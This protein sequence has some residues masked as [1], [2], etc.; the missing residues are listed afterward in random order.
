ME[1]TIAIDNAT[2][3]TVNNGMPASAN[4]WQFYYTNG[5]SHWSVLYVGGGII[6]NILAYK[7][8]HIEIAFKKYLIKIDYYSY[9]YRDPKIVHGSVIIE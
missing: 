6:W 7:S 1:I 2:N 5:P 3:I 4:S 9:K 8:T